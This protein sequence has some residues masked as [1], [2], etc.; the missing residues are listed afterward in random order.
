MIAAALFGLGA[1]AL[2]SGAW[3]WWTARAAR[4]EAAAHQASAD[5]ARQQFQPVMSALAPAATPAPIDLDAT[6]RIVREIDVVSDRHTS[7]QDDLAMMAHNDY[8]GVDPD[9]LAARKRLLKLQFA[10]VAKE[11]EQGDKEA[12]WDFSRKLVL[13]TLSV[14]S[15]SGKV[16]VG[17]PEGGFSVDRE[18]AQKLLAELEAEQADKKRLR[19]DIDGLQAQLFDATYDYSTVYTRVVDDWDRLCV[20]RDRAYLAAHDKDWKTVKASAD[21]AIAQ[22]P[23]EREAHLLDAMAMIEDGDPDDRDAARTLLTAYIHDHPDETAPAFLLLGVAEEKAGNAEAARLNFEQSAAYYPKQADKLTDMLDPYKMRAYLRKS[24]EGGYI[25][26]QYQSM[27]LGAGYYSP[28]LQMAKADF[29]HGDVYAGRQKVTDHFARRRSQQQW[30]FI[31]QDIDY[32]HDL[33]GP[34]MHD[35]FPEDSYLD[36][37]VSPSMFGGNSISVGVVN[38]SDKTLHNATLI[39]A[40]HFTDMHPSD[41]EPFAAGK[42]QPA[43]LA[44]DTT[45]FGKVDVTTKLWGV[46][47]GVSDIVQDRAVS[48]PS[49]TRSPRR[50]NSTTHARRTA[51]RP[52]WRHPG[53]RRC[54]SSS[55]RSSAG[56]ENMRSSRWNRTTGSQTT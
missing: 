4:L 46:D 16:G 9:V 38:R 45:D 28:D 14:V 21:A 53:T 7:M 39:L 52:S 50:R 22:A 3:W 19:Q 1:V 17:A 34:Q 44:H 42:T 33:L 6:I 48:T 31:L 29:D 32:A 47:K 56:S 23:Q 55:R 26:E 25:L 43:V 13:S 30:A 54:S 15:A 40:L 10:L 24:R 51:R 35:L 41:Y 37:T 12:A 20:L 11:E 8:R 49:R 18:Q 5:Q 2:P 27:M 36:L